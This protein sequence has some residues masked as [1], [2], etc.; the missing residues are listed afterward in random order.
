MH[1][2]GVVT[3]HNLFFTFLVPRNCEMC[4]ELGCIPQFY[5]SFFR[6]SPCLPIPYS[7][8]YIKYKTL[9]IYVPWIEKEKKIQVSQ[10]C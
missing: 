6:M 5:L 1:Y 8:F 4:G 3:E 10:S 2:V 7:L 9:V